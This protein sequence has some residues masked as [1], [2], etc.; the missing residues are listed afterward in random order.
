MLMKQLQVENYREKTVEERGK[1]EENLD[2]ICKRK[3][4]D[5]KQDLC[6]GSPTEGCTLGP[7]L[8]P[9]KVPAMV[10]VTAAS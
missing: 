6:R 7:T 9:F 10:Q 1:D 4:V 5:A 8:L 3:I 2:P